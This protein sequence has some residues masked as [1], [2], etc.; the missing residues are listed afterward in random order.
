MSKAKHFGAVIAALAVAAALTACGSSSSSSSA[1][2]ASTSGPTTTAAGVGSSTTAKKKYNITFVAA[3]VNDSYF[4]TIKC[5]AL[6]E[7]KKLGINLK[8][9]GPTTNEVP[10]ELQAFQAASLTNPD[11]MVLAP[12][13]NTGFG[14][15]VSPLMAKG[16]PVVASG[17]TLSP[18]DALTTFI[19]NFLTGGNSLSGEVGKL[20]GGT[21]T[22]G[23]V[24]DTT[25]NKTDS[26]RYTGLV[27][28][29]HKEYPKLK[30]LAPQYGQNSSAT[31][32]SITSALI[33]GN[34][35]LK[36]VYASSGPE[37][38]GAAAAIAA[39]HDTG[40]IKLMSFDSSPPQIALLKRNQ[41]AAT[42]A[43]APLLD[44]ELTVKAVVDYLNA[45]PN[46]GP[47]K[48]SAGLVYTPQKLLTPANVNTPTAASY[49][50]LTSCANVPSGSA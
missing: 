47:V 14:G 3:L 29:L 26:D 32:A 5:G 9:T 31:A 21:G 1:G 6:A 37:A 27:P 45:H 24:A 4:V 28:I 50:Y 2:S 39:A 8:W 20:T 16:I 48:S 17:E 41:L 15:V 19:T 13:S 35:N 49:Q 25:G 11:G 42:I 23:I 43:Q 33:A 7:A 36:L 40:K 38:V 22:M 10:Q 12:F 44:G 46:K 34:P 18:P 30:V